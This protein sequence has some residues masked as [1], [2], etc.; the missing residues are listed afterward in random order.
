MKKPNPS[1]YF[2][3]RRL[4]E[5]KCSDIVLI[6]IKPNKYIIAKLINNTII[7]EYAMNS[8]Y[9][10]YYVYRFSLYKGMSVSKNKIEGYYE[11]V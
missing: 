4:L 10:L 9:C 3:L 6:Q 7:Y 11:I 8:S 5:G 2:H 1:I